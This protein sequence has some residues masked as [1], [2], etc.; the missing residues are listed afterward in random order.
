MNE[1]QFKDKIILITGGVQGIGLKC[2]E[3][4][5]SLGSKVI[6]TCKSN[7]SYENYKRSCLERN[8]QLEKL[9]L[10][11]EISIDM[12]HKKLDK[13]DILIN[14]ATLLKGG[15]EYRIENFSDV[16]NVNLMGLM[17]ICHTFLP[18][19]ALS[20]GNIINMSSV[21]SKVSI[22]DAPSYSATKS[23]I[24]SLTKSMASC[25][26]THKVRVNCVAPG[27]IKGN[28]LNKILEAYDNNDEIIRR[29]PLKRFGSPEEVAEALMF[30]ASNEASYITGSTIFVDGG[31][32]IT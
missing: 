17:R 27:F 6:V 10:T 3:R 25:W 24:E 14:N 2:A 26:A 20:Q 32:S 28:T 21:S 23:A 16:V 18:K 1:Q 30:L 8:I 4:F 19:L 5:S 13:L 22:P 29:I 12:L 31:Y 11:N 7:T 9:D 15:I